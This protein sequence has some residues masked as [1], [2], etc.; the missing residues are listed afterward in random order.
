MATWIAHLRV[1]EKLLAIYKDLDK[2]SFLVGNIGPD[3][4]VPNEDWSSFTPPK[5]I[6]HWENEAGTIDAEDFK[7]R[8]LSNIKE[9]TNQE[10][11]FVL[12]YY[13]HLLSDIQ[14]SKYLLKRK[15]DPLYRDNLAK[16]KNFIWVIK[17]DWYGQDHLYLRENKQNVFYDIFA[18][19][20]EF[21]NTYFD[22]FPSEAFTRQ[23]NYISN[24][25]LHCKENVDR[26]FIY[27]T[28]EE[29]DGYVAAAYDAVK[30]ELSK[31]ELECS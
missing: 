6:S 27:F 25:Y 26:D 28:K 16:D 20:K 31:L 30:Y 10:L 12:G 17:D 2:E 5:K 9:Y 15:D 14:W 22:F 21:P 29:M 4:G 3:S 1:A 8:Y 19:I 11:S 24:Y 18:K 23:V 7:K 13:V